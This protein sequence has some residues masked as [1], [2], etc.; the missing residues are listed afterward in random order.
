M[1][2]NCLIALIPTVFLTCNFDLSKKELLACY[3][4]SL[5]VF[6]LGDILEELVKLNKK[7]KDNGTGS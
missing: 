5:F 1:V 7:E 4:G 6:I 2:L 3:F